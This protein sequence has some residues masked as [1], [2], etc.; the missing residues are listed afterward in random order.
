MDFSPLANPKM[1]GGSNLL[2]KM[3]WDNP[4]GALCLL[5]RTGSREQ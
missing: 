5:H 2:R 3:G 1:F 4:S